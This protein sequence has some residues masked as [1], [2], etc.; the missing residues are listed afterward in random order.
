MKKIKAGNCISLLLIIAGIVLIAIPSASRIYTWYWQNRALESYDQLS[1]IF[2][3]QENIGAGEET[4]PA[5]SWDSNIE[6]PESVAAKAA[7]KSIGII[8]I[9]K[10]DVNLPILKD[11]TKKNMLIGAGWL[12][13][14]SRPGD[15]GNAALAAHRSYTYG[16]FFNRLDEIDIGDEFLIEFGGE[17]YRYTVFNKLVIEPTDR[18]VLA[19]NKKDRVAT[20]ITC[21]P[22]RIATHRLIIQGK[23]D[24]LQ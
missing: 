1:E 6:E 12:S 5:P 7:V 9:P 2:T 4:E 23:I 22:I 19:R 10:I 24:E 8:K 14:T 13:E 18:S 15:I 20:L 3:E 11:A 21:T 16:R 17:E